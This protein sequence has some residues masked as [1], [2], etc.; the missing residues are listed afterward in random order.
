[1]RFSSRILGDHGDS[2]VEARKTCEATEHEKGKQ[3]VVERCAK[4]ETEC[5]GGGTDTEGDLYID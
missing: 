2:Y 3:K 5:G 1:M 4:T